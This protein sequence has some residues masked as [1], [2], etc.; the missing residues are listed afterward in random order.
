MQFRQIANQ[1]DSFFI[2]YPVQLYFFLLATFGREEGVKVES[3]I[4]LLFATVDSVL[5]L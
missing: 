1:I 5:R 2:Y 4:I 3:C